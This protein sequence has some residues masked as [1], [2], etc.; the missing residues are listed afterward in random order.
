M[1]YQ[2]RSEQR[3]N[4]MQLDGTVFVLWDSSSGAGAEVWPALGFNC[5]RWQTT[6]K[7]QTLDLLYSDPQIFEGARATRSGIPVLFP[8]PNR[9]RGGHFSWLGQEYQLPL[10]DA[11][12]KHAIHGF[13]AF[14]PWR[15]IDHGS[16][17]TSAWVTGEFTASVDG[18]EAFA[19]W[20]ADYRLRLTHRLTDRAL[21]IEAT[22]TN[23]DR[24]PLPFGL[25]Y[26][27]YFRVPF[28][29]G[30]SEQDY[31][32]K[33]PARAYWE[34]DENLPTGN[35]RPAEDPRDLR[36][37][38]WCVGLSLD[39]V[40]TN[41]DRPTTPVAEQL[42]FRGSVR[43]ASNGLAVEVYASSTFRELVVFTPPH[44]QAICLEPYT[45]TTDALNLQQ[46]GVDAGLLVL[47]PGEE[48]HGV[49]ELR[50]PS[51]A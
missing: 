50:A 26:H 25:G 7:D 32:V 9:L 34:L 43:Q 14:K 28:Q 24:K 33:C 22:V 21:R 19:L 5:F 4:S 16:D 30:H 48:W 12:K 6:W 45:C 47:Q 3:P 39:D 51:A 42:H 15:V 31:W 1:P 38:R 8:F 10:N 27:T 41:F 13:A 36:A 18:K 40:L 37:E 20:P 35:R 17:A 2:I 29:S 46:R 23:P 49:V 11:S 44:R